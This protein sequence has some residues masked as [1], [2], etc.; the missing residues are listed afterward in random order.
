MVLK[1]PEKIT[2]QIELRKELS[3]LRYGG[4]LS[5]DRF[6]KQSELLIDKAQ[7]AIT[8]LFVESLPEKANYIGEVIQESEGACQPEPYDAGYEDG[9]NS[10]LN[11]ITKEWE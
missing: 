9:Y 10:C 1:K 11:Q 6:K 3:K 7:Q 8:K 4:L 5:D 2:E